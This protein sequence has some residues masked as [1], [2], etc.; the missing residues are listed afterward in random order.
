[1]LRGGKEPSRWKKATM[2]NPE[3]GP[4]RAAAIRFIGESRAGRGGEGNGRRTFAMIE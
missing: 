4:I 2:S 3:D 1:V